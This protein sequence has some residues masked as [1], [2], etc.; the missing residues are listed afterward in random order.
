MAEQSIAGA[1]SRR[2]AEN[3]TRQQLSKRSGVKQAKGSNHYGQGHALLKLAQNNARRFMEPINDILDIEKL[4][5]G[6]IELK[7]KEIDIVELVRRTYDDNLPY[8]NQ[9]NVRFRMECQDEKIVA[10]GDAR[11]LGQVVA[12]LLSNAAKFSNENDTL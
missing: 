8:A 9:Y 11:R 1:V 2:W 5:L 10:M 6:L 4:E 7:T 12:N 3:I